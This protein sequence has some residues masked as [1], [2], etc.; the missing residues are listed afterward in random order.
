MFSINADS[1][2][3]AVPQ[4]AKMVEREFRIVSA[5]Y[6]GIGLLI[7]AIL[8]PLFGV[9]DYYAN[10]DRFVEFMVIRMVATTVVLVSMY[11]LRK[12]SRLI[13]ILGFT[14]LGAVVAQDSWFLSQSPESTIQQM[15]LT[16]VA[17]FVGAGLVLLWPFRLALVF[18]VFAAVINLFF[19]GF[20]SDVSFVYL[21][22]NGGFLIAACALFSMVMIVTRH[23]SMLQMI[24]S[25]VELVENNDHMALQNC[26][27]NEKSIEL[28]KSNQRL[29]DFAHMASHDLKTPLRGI[30]NLT[31]WIREDCSEMINKE[32]MGHLNMIHRQVQKMELM[33]SEM[34]EY[35]KSLNAE[36]CQ[37]WIC[38]DELIQEVIETVDVGGKTKFLVRSGVPVVKC[39]RLVVSQVLQNLLSNAIKHND[40]PKVEIVITVIEENGVVRFSVMDNGPG[41]ACSDHHRLFILYDTLHAKRGYE[42]TGI[43]LPVAKKMI[44][45]SGGSLWVDSDVG[46]GSIFHFTIPKS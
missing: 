31:T 36:S 1:S 37:E 29:R 30:K 23:A 16:F 5:R 2:E 20:F 24:K 33:I 6:L 46:S 15:S 17:D 7:A 26:I 43:G 39:S 27:I 12:N 14:V 13:H 18:T 22:L 32:G 8:N 35:S 40:K 34:L 3:S 44:E 38:L 21:F 4:Y 28:E 10:N 45:E 9:F 11:L 41:I 25:R 19:F 42:S